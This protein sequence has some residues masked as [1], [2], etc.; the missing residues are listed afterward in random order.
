MYFAVISDYACE[1]VISTPWVLFVLPFERRWESDQKD[2]CK[3]EVLGIQGRARC[4]W[5]YNQL[6]RV[7]AGHTHKPMFPEVG[8]PLPT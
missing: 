6:K 8:E 4:P 1:P 2:K 3:K 7:I 5:R